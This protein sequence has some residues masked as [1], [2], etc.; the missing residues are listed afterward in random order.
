MVHNCG[1]IRESRDVPNEEMKEA[2]AICNFRCAD[3]TK[4]S[5][6][7]G[8]VS[9]A[10]TRRKNWRGKIVPPVGKDKAGLLSCVPS[11][12]AQSASDSSTYPLLF[13]PLRSARN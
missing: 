3:C 5:Y 11:G 7:A 2:D 8:S 1:F 9:G 12:K 10:A 4:Q 13:I 6:T